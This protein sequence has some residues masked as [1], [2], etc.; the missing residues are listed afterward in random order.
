MNLRSY[1]PDFVAVEQDGSHWLLETK[2]QETS[3]VQ[4][5]DERRNVGATTPPPSRAAGSP[6]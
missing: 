6:T 1:Y 3:E 2:G 4:R 5:K